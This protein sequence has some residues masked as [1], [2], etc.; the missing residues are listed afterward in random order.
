MT[1]INP[2]VTFFLNL[3]RAQTIL[4]ERF[5]RGLGG[6]GFNEFLIL[7]HL[8]QAEAGKLRRVDL[9]KKI[10]LT[11]SG[12]TRLLLPMEKIGLIKSGPPS[13]DARVRFVIM[14]NS[15]RQKMLE[16]VERLELLGEDL[17]PSSK[18]KNLGQLS[19]LLLEISGRAL[20]G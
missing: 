11:A 4:A 1:K 18:N 7:Y 17:I 10:G 20:M 8:E 14:S 15:G 12:V 3:G 19:E 5:D 9:A 2:T 13:D 16:A 6:L